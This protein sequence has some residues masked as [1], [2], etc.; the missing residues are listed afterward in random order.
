ME[1]PE[2]RG[3][4]M[5]LRIRRPFVLVRCIGARHQGSFEEVVQGSKLERNRIAR[6]FQS[7]KSHSG[8]DSLVA[9]RS[10]PDPALS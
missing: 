3:D 2:V 5:D 1:R 10:I 6:L 9:R 7:S 4:A 8:V